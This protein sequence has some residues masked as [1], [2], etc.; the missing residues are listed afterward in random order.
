MPTR[1]CLNFC[2]PLW[3]SRVYLWRIHLFSLAVSK[4]LKEQCIMPSSIPRVNVAM[5]VSLFI[6]LLANLRTVWKE[7]FKS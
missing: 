1:L 5:E 6:F 2:R 7:A 4:E 3:T